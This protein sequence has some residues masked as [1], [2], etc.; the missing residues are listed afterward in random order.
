MGDP[1]FEQWCERMKIDVAGD[2][3]LHVLTERT[4]ARA[5][6]EKTL[7]QSVASHYED[8]ARISDRIARLGFQKAA[9]ILRQML[10]QTKRA[11]SGHLGEILATEAVPAYLGSFHIPIKRLRWTD[12]RESALRGEDLIGIEKEGEAIRFLKGES[13]SRASLTP[14]TV[15]EARETL[16][17]NDGRPSQHAFGF[18]MKILNDLGQEDLAQIFEEYMLMKSI[19][20]ESLVHLTF[21]LS[22]NDAETALTAD[23]RNYKGHIEQHSISMRIRDHQTFIATIYDRLTANGPQR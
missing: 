11:R 6:V 3:K 13:K 9:E 16:N 7:D 19:P 20:N 17:A 8:P 2:R 1:F 22:G 12:G 5:E 21:A 14:S 23:L 4:G 10:P 15:A 18:I